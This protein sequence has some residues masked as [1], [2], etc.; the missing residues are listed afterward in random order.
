MAQKRPATGRTSRDD[1]SM[2]LEKID[3]MSASPGSVRPDAAEITHAA[4]RPDQV[5][6]TAELLPQVADVHI[7]GTVEL[8]RPSPIQGGRELVAGD[9]PPRGVDQEFENVVFDSGDGDGRSRRPRPGV[10][11]EQA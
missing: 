4:H 6:V 5:A 8:G 3:R 1:Q 11:R 2:T 7:E 9:D 10:P